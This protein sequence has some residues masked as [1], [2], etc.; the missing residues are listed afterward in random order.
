M[1]KTLPEYCWTVLQPQNELVMVK[2]GESGYY[3]QREENAPWDAKNVNHLNERLGVTKG[4]EQAMASG[5]MF[6]WDNEMAN[7]NNYN[8]DGSWIE[9]E[10]E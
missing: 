6:G 3:P 9:K 4:Q 2:R 1:T 5:S 7:P 10:D 8:D